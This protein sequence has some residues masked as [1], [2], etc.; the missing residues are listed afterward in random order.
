MIEPA[1]LL[2]SACIE[3]AQRVARALECL[4][5]GNP[6]SIE[7]DAERSQTKTSSGD[8]GDIRV[9]L[10]QRRS[11]DTRAIRHEPCLRIGLLPE[12]TKRTLLKIVEKG[13]IGLRGNRKHQPHKSTKGA[14]KIFRAFCASLWPKLHSLIRSGFAAKVRNHCWTAIRS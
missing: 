6:I 9:T 14:E 5:S 3:E 11:I 8:A 2:K 10:R 13:C 12:V 4:S 7:S 1:A